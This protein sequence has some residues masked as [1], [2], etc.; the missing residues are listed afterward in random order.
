VRNC[1]IDL[2]LDRVTVVQAAQSG[3]GGNQVSPCS[4]VRHGLT[5]ECVFRQPKTRPI[6]VVVA[7]I[8][9]HPLFQVSL[10]QDDDVVQQVPSETPHPTLRHSVLPRAPKDSAQGSALSFADAITSVPNF[11]SWSKSRNLCA[12][13]YGHAQLRG[14][15]KL[16]ANTAGRRMI[17]ANPDVQ[18]SA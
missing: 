8:L 12:G 17:P 15:P 1:G 11:E 16:L 14:N 6:L 7:H 13:T 2:C 10:V 4:T 3:K 9:S 18:Q 5:L